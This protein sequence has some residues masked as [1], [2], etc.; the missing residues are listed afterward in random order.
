M[1]DDPGFGETLVGDGRPLLVLSA[2]AL[3][4]FGAFA[5]FLAATGRFL[6]QDVAFLGMDSDQL[7][8][9]HG[10]RIVHFMVHDRLT[11]GGVLVATGVLYLWLIEFPLKRGESW[12]WWAL[13]AS[14]AAGLL[15]FLAYLGYG[16]LDTWHG[17]ATLGLLPLF[18][19]G[20][21]RTRVLRRVH[22]P[23]PPLD[24]LTRRGRGRALLLT[25]A[26][27]IVAAGLTI[28]TV[29]ATLVFVP[30]DLEFIRASRAELTAINARLIPLI[31]HDR[32]GFGGALFSFGIAMLACLIFQPL[33]RSLWQALAVAGIFGFAT[34]IGIHPAIG[35]TN[36]SHLAPAVMGCVMYIVGLALARPGD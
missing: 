3:V 6:P 17:V 28:T 36:V 24:L 31:A 7:C 16:Y 21:A 20:L 19:A 22:V 34:A 5:M 10:C 12:A 1:S 8:A 13:L 29:G 15:S 26:V 32:A 4:A 9:L 11:F 27:A 33:G 2:L 25:T 35:Y 23:R 18:A 14:S 30:T